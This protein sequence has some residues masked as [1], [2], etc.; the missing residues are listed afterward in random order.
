MGSAP[1]GQAGFE[2]RAGLVS[3]PCVNSLVS[4][5]PFCHE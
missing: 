5:S 4:L 1:E 3:L 2:V